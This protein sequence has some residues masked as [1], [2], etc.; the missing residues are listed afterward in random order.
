MID[1]KVIRANIPLGV[2]LYPNSVAAPA[3]PVYKLSDFVDTINL[4]LK[5]GYTLHEKTTFS[6]DR[7][8]AKDVDDFP[9]GAPF[10]TTG[11]SLMITQCMIKC[12]SKVKTD[13]EYGM[14]TN[15]DLRN[16]KAYEDMIN[17]ELNNGWELHGPQIDSKNPH[18]KRFTIQALVKR[19]AVPE[20]C[21]KSALEMNVDMIQ[22]DIKSLSHLYDNINKLNHTVEELLVNS[23]DKESNKMPP[24]KCKE[25]H[26]Y[27]YIQ[28]IMTILI[29]IIS[30][31]IQMKY[32]PSTAMYLN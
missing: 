21:E 27:I 14:I 32:S 8:G 24:L 17:K 2:I 12:S 6:D 19:S 18:H 15:M 11:P 29:L 4:Y 1:Y 22:N 16:I 10:V 30:V 26:Y 20:I 5:N 7:V 23:E 13:T 25:Q 3:I 31:L 28:F 9:V